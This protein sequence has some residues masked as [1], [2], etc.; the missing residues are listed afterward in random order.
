MEKWMSRIPDQKKLVLINIPGSHDSCAFA[1]NRMGEDFA[2]TQYHNIK[3]Q[4]E[5]GIRKL[6][7]RITTR[8]KYI[9]TDE[10]I[11]TCHGIC[12]C[13]VSTKFCDFRRVTYKS[14]LLDVKEFLERNPTE[15]VM[16]GTY[17][18]RGDL[19]PLIRSTEIF[20]KYV[21]N[22]ALKYN[23]NITLGEARGKIIYITEYIDTQKDIKDFKPINKDLI[24]GTGINDIHK[25]YY[26]CNT[27]EINGNAL[28][29]EMK[30]MFKQ[31]NYTLNQ[32][33]IE[34]KNNKIQFPISY[35][36]S[37][38]G[39]HDICLPFPI[40]QASYVNSYLLKFGVLR[41]GY[42][43]GWLNIDFATLEIVSTFVDTNFNYY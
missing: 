24:V 8:N 22:I 10:D 23:N 29:L 40:T 31:Y 11:I 9:E 5:I 3:E 13:Y 21:G 16:I 41:K 28:V 19:V 39:E 4:L 2:R 1:M 18:G 42:Y 38:T 25:N 26:D 27:Y 34:E 35:S 32:A 14:V 12:D 20:F 6:D 43:Y 36:V 17:K 30:D 37:C 7:I 15:T 33:E